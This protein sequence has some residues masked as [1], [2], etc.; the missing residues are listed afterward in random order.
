MSQPLS[1]SS[2]FFAM[3][4]FKKKKVID[5]AFEMPLTTLTFK[6]KENMKRKWFFLQSIK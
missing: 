1:K 4:R 3:D 2:E 6:R 5:N